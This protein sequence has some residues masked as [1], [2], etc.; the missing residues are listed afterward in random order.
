MFGVVVDGEGVKQDFAKAVAYFSLSAQQGNIV[1]LYNLAQMH[2]HG[3]GTAPS[4]PLSVQLYKKV[5]ERGTWSS[6]IHE[7]YKLYQ[8]GE[9]TAALYRYEKAAHQG[10]EAAQSNAAY[11]Y[12]K[13]LGMES[14]ETFNLG[15]DSEHATETTTT[16]TS[17]E[18]DSAKEENLSSNVRYQRAL[19][20]FQMSSEQKNALSH[21]RLGDYYYYGLGTH[22]NLEKA[23]M[24]Y[25][26]ASDMGNPQAMFNLG[27]MHQV[28]CLPVAP[29]AVLFHWVY[30][31]G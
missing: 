24:F 28:C 11:M 20:Y 7:A 8:K 18:Q 16:T 9:Y 17:E 15:D 10:Y 1:A 25:Q 12:D 29:V 6:A 30:V 31:A 27:F 4:C 13:E 2:E 21:L 22:V 23:A 3:L 14:E 26:A 5:A 19:E